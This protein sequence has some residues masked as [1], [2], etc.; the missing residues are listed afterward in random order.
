MPYP[1]KDL[2]NRETDFFMTN[3]GCT[4]SRGFQRMYKLEEGSEKKLPGQLIEIKPEAEWLHES[5]KV[6]IRQKLYLK[7]IKSFGDFELTIMKNSK[8]IFNHKQFLNHE[9]RNWH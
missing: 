3:T 9:N 6:G 2:R 8:F 5:A 4:C 7:L 1:E